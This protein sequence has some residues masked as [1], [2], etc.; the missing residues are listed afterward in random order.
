MM[1]ATTSHR[2]WLSAAR[3]LE[4]TLAVIIGFILMVFGLGLGVTMVMLPAGLVI[5]LLG[6]AL[7]VTGLFAR[8][9]GP[10]R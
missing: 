5:G 4:H 9:G 10:A 1:H 7:V 6:V 3:L 8:T 2:L